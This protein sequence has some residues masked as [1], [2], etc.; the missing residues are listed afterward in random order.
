MAVARKTKRAPTCSDLPSISELNRLVESESDDDGEKWWKKHL[1]EQAARDA[2]FKKFSAAV[3]KAM[4][5][6]GAFEVRSQLE[7]Q[8]GKII[9]HKST[10]PGVAYQVT[11]IDNR[12]PSGH[13]DSRS[14][15]AAIKRA[16]EDVHPK[17]KAKY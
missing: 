16:W 15:D 3:K 6:A 10:R 14:L 9:I 8:G 13:T 11:Q 4:R 7:R 1:R 5:S 2:Q 12:G 17:E